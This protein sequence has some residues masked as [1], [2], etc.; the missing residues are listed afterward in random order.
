MR[1][2]TVLP[3][4]FFALLG[5]LQVC[6]ATDRLV[7]LQ[8]V[9]RHGDRSPIATFPTDEHQE[10]AWP[11]GWGELSPKGMQ[12]HLFLAANR[13]R[14]RYVDEI[15][16]L[17]P[18]YRSHEVYFTS[19]DVNRTILSAV[20]NTIGLYSSSSRVGIDYP[21][22]EKGTPCWPATFVP[23]PIH[24][25]GYD[26]DFILNPDAN[27]QRQT[28]LWEHVK[29]SPEFKKF[30]NSQNDFIKFLSDNAGIE[31]IPDNLWIVQDSLYIEQLYNISL[32]KWAQSQYNGKPVYQM[33]ES[34]MNEVERF[35]N[36][37]DI[38]NHKGV[39]FNAE[40]ARIRGGGLLWAII[41]NMQEK[42]RCIQ[43]PSGPKCGFYSNLKF[44]AYSAHDTTL[45]ALFRVLGFS[46]TNYRE[47][48]YPHY[49]SAV[50]IELWATPAGAYYTKFIYWPL[51][52]QE[53]DVTPEITGC[54]G[55]NNTGCPIETLFQRSLPFRPFP[56]V[57][58]WCA[59]PL[60]KRNCK[61]NLQKTSWNSS[62]TNG[63]MDFEAED[64]AKF[65]AR[66]RSDANPRNSW[67]YEF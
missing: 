59:T 26:L 29:C 47:D 62:D 63:F 3:V 35:M 58:T 8:A 55:T 25:E 54:P 57:A 53:Y 30:W 18:Q 52:E 37:I 28:A 7:F 31:I 40:I 23:V 9:W 14:P 2:N 45:A 56:D 60:F 4:A 21:A 39:D 49:S 33:I 48:G 46:K 61:L 51:G 41:G 22:C 12:Q 50:T 67:R 43:D 16:F 64:D 19:T 36:G 38:K 5:I 6:Q 13:L 17:N 11:Q 32:P 10:D 65:V 34:L 20:A 15:K 66:R 27:C 24:T 42:A 44:F 1:V